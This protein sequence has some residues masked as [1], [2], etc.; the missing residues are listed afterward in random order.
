MF[1]KFI[2]ISERYMVSAAP[3]DALAETKKGAFVRTASLELN[4]ISSAEGSR[5]KPESG[6]YHLYISWACPWANRCA[7]V[8]HLKGLQDAIGITTVHPTWQKTKPDD[9]SD[10]HWGWAFGSKDS[11]F[12]NANG[13]GAL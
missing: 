11:V 7:T 10:T 13:S 5:F 4:Q 2:K 8:I 1:R 9:D 3:K 12:A 6:R